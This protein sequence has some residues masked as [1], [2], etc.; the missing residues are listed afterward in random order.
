MGYQMTKNPWDY[1]TIPYG[2]ELASRGRELPAYFFQTLYQHPP[3]FTILLSLSMRMF[4]P[5]DIGAALVPL[6]F[7]VLL[8]PLTYFLG[9]LVSDW[10]IGLVSAFLLWMDPINIICSQKI[11]MST[12]V[13]F[14]HLLSSSCFIYGLIKEKPHYFIFSGIASGLGT[15]TVYTGVLPVITHAIFA[16]CYKRELFRVRPF[17][18]GLFIPVLFLI[19]WMIWNAQVYGL[20]DII[21]TFFKIFPHALTVI[22]SVKPYGLPII[23]G[24]LFYFV[25]RKR[26]K[27]ILGAQ[28]K[29]TPIFVEKLQRLL[30][31]ALFGLF[32]IAISRALI[33]SFHLDYMPGTSWG[34]FG[35]RD[36]YRGLFYFAQLLKFSLIYLLSF[37]A[38][39]LYGHSGNKGA[40]FIRLSAA[41]TLLFFVI[42]GNYQSRYILPALPFLIVLAAI[43]LYDLMDHL[44]RFQHFIP[45][46][47]LKAFLILFL[48]FS[49]CRTIYINLIISF[50]HQFCYF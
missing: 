41:V 36:G 11:W 8:I 43:V 13:A 22:N 20:N 42:W 49:V 38:L 50:P 27:E 5:S 33:N 48:S 23:F 17:I 4:G 46:V 15:V 19:P 45:R 16:V 44:N 9:R 30:P 39:F 29:I 6:F 37:A 34:N 2:M 10:R 26:L 14:F 28:D 47:A 25:F 31:I 3:L 1:N 40:L 7:G 32:I 12:P 24:L 35:F 21:G 18:I